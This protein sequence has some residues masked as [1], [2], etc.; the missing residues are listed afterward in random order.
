[1]GFISGARG[2]Q[3]RVRRRPAATAI[4]EP[5]RN[6]EWRSALLEMDYTI[7]IRHSY[8][9]H[10]HVLQSV[11]ILKAFQVTF[12]KMEHFRPFMG[13]PALP[14]SILGVEATQLLHV[15]GSAT[16]ATW[17]LLLPTTL[18]STSLPGSTASKQLPF[19]QLPFLAAQL[20]SHTHRKISDL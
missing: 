16:P 10:H 4:L 13:D 5:Q 2:G 20:A 9:G 7:G 19:S 3:S 12:Y 14:V 8:R 17:K 15:N 6:R 18:F 1:M 11:F